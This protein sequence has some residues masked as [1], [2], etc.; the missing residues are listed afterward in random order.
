MDIVNDIAKIP[1]EL[2][3]EGASFYFFIKGIYGENS[4]R[5]QI[6]K[7]KVESP[8]LIVENADTDVQLKL[9]D[10][11]ENMDSSFSYDDL[12]DEEKQKFRE[13][14]AAYQKK[15]TYHL[16]LNAGASS[17]SIPDESYREEADIVNIH[18]NGI[19][20]HEGLDYTLS[21]RT[22]QLTNPAANPS[23]AEITVTRSTIVNSNDYSLLKGDKG[24]T[25]I[26]I[27]SIAAST[28]NEDGG[29]NAVT[30]SLTDGT[31]TSFNIKNGS[32]GT[33]G[34]TGV[35][36]SSIVQTKTSTADDG[37]NVITVT[38]SNGQTSTFTVQ[39]G[40]KGSKGDKG[41]TGSIADINGTLLSMV[42]PIG[43]IYMSVN[44]VSPAS[45]LGGTWEQLRDRFLLGAGSSYSN[46]STGG[47]ATVSLSTANLPSHSH[48][49]TIDTKSLTGYAP[50]AICV[51][52]SGA[53]ASSGTSGIVKWS[54]SGN[55]DGNSGDTRQRNGRIDID[56]SHNHTGTIG[57]TGS[58][59]AHENMP[60]YLTVYMWKRTA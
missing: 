26:G 53:G 30:I 27:S 45:F 4:R 58:G 44:S 31:S 41:D 34:A 22:V 54:T 6:L 49:L 43:S 36:I 7:L 5:S 1:P 52:G 39:N 46:G 23:T 15:L 38:L 35:G 14:F 18:L 9:I 12:S 33:I 28:S 13:G 50:T 59:T 17:F 42:Y 2:I 24:D 60:P 51:E 56:A 25:G 10:L 40:S 48:S 55:A 11:I 8:I 19:Y 21:G 16:G 37:D 29:N 32:K 3:S 47:S 57:N 20:L